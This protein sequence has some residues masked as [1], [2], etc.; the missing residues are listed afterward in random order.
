MTHMV[1]CIF[2]NFQRLSNFDPPANAFGGPF[3]FVP[4]LSQPSAMGHFWSLL[5]LRIADAFALVSLCGRLFPRLDAP[6]ALY[7]ALPVVE[8][9]SGSYSRRPSLRPFTGGS[10]PFL[11]SQRSRVP[12]HSFSRNF[13][14]RGVARRSVFVRLNPYLCRPTASSPLPCTHLSSSCFSRIDFFTL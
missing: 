6:S 14:P 12:P 2:R 3:S 10:F 5:R 7:S 4:F 8:N 9:A 13:P 11:K 1:D